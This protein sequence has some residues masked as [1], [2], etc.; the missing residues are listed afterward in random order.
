MGGCRGSG[1][2]MSR[3][4]RSLF[5]SRLRL[6]LTSDSHTHPERQQR[7]MSS[8]T[9]IPH[10]SNYALLGAMKFQNGVGGT[11]RV[12]KIQPGGGVYTPWKVG[13][14]EGGRAVLPN[15]S[16][17]PALQVTGRSEDRALSKRGDCDSAGKERRSRASNEPWRRN[18]WMSKSRD[19]PDGEAKLFD[20]ARGVGLSGPPDLKRS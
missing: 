3:R 7:S 13:P 10:I 1:T 18:M 19:P 9:A 11:G 20:E 6:D 4:R 16:W 2:K 15:I 14:L 5:E 17:A 12:W 8:G